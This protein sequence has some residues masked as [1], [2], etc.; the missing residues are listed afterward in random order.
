[1]GVGAGEDAADSAPAD[2]LTGLS[3]EQ[4]GLLSRPG[5]NRHAFSGGKSLLGL[6]Q[7]AA[8]KAPPAACPHTHCPPSITAIPC[9]QLKEKMGPPPAANF[10]RPRLAHLS[11]EG[12][13]TGGGG[14]G[15]RS[16][17]YRRP[18]EPTPSHGGGVNE[19][20][21][22]QIMHR[23]KESLRS[24][25]GLLF[26]T[27]GSSSEPATAGG[28]RPP[29]S[30]AHSVA[31][32]ADWEAPSPVH[33]SLVADRNAFGSEPRVLVADHTPMSQTPGG[34]TGSASHI[35]ATPLPTPAGLRHGEAGQGKAEGEGAEW[36]EDAGDV[37]GDE[38]DSRDLDRE[39]CDAAGGAGRGW[40]GERVG[41]PAA[42]ERARLPP[43]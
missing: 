17:T 35:S 16:R 33:P 18:R 4:G 31:S 29:P 34:G 22:A 11:E 30:P 27:R 15:A 9:S 1:M 13:D 28:F 5:A 43:F 25:D 14:A 2:S 21:A 37:Q 10:K 42:A 23:V 3:N 41:P 38:E 20:K 39:W 26:T 32:S 40:G 8:Q 7:L 19:E 36:A 12:D 6:D 24:S